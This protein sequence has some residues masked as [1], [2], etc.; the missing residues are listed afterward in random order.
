MIRPMGSDGGESAI[1]ASPILL[2]ILIM[3]L[4]ATV[5]LWRTRFI[6]RKTAY[7][8]FAVLTVAVIASGYSLYTS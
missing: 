8:A 7:I 5:F 3:M 1:S 6:R 4:G 2:V